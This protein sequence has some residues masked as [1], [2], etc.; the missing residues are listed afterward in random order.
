MKAFNKLLEKNALSQ[1]YINQQ[2]TMM[3][4][5]SVLYKT[6]LHHGA[7]AQLFCA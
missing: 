1:S 2:L 7:V 5:Y 3:E 4:E 6:I